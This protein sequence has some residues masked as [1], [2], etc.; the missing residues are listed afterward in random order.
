MLLDRYGSVDEDGLHGRARELPFVGVLFALGGLALAG[1]PPFGLGLGKAIAEH[2][3]A[4]RLPWLPAV[5]VAVSALTGAA[6]LRAAAHVFAGAG[7]TGTHHPGQETTGEEEEEEPE[8]RGA[9]RRVPAPMVVVPAV[10]LAASLAAGLPGVARAFARAAVVFTDRD[11]YLAAAHAVPR[12]VAALPSVP[13]AG[14]APEGVALGCLSAAMAVA[15]AALSVWGGDPRHRT[16]RETARLLRA[17]GRRTVLPLR[18]LHSGHLGDYVSW[19]AGG[20]AVLLVVLL[21][22]V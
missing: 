15:L 6:V 18:R 2:A 1:L 14:W 11:G 5:Y 9:T 12:A 4:E 17:L 22:Q 21:A 16:S 19:L 7:H 8:V 13:P 10:L 20:M 3:A